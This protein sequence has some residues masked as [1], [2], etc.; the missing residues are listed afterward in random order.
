MPAG[1]TGPD[2]AISFAR[3][4]RSE[5]Y[6]ASFPRACASITG[7][8]SVAGSAGSP[9]RS[10]AIA[11]RS[12]SSTAGAIS[13][14]RYRTRSELQR[15]PA[16]RKA[17]ATTASTTC[18]GSALES[19]IMA[20]RPPVSAISGAIGPSRSARTRW[21]ARAVAVEPVKATPAIL[22]SVTRACP[23]PPLPGRR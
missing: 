8:T 13:S 21:M 1:G 2:S 16:E 19:T 5:T 20:F 17:L 4:L 23:I 12:M 15:W 11:P 7:P 10:A 3:E 6:S 22:G 18:S 9:M 14:C